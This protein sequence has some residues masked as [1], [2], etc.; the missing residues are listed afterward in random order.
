MKVF[1]TTRTKRSPAFVALLVWLFALASG[2]ANACLLELPDRHS[3]AVSAS[4]PTAKWV[5]DDLDTST[6]SSLKCCDDGTIAL[7][8]GHS[9]VDQIDPGSAPLVATLW[10]P[11]AH[12]ASVPRRLDDL[13]LHTVGPP[14]RVRYS[15]LAL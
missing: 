14:L 3:N 8:N 12:V 9:G 15:R 1:S 13:Q 7:P 2:V 5:G 11:S 6:E 10:T 4:H